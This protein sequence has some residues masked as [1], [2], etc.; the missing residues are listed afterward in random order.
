MSA[1][2]SPE[3]DPRDDAKRRAAAAFGR[4]LDA[5]DYTLEAAARVLR[6]SIT[7]V[8]KLRSTDPAHRDAVPS[9]VDVLLADHV[10]GE[11]FLR[12][13]VV[14]RLALHGEAPV[15]T[16]EQRVTAATQ[17]ALT[18][19]H[20]GVGVMA[21]GVLEGPEKPPLDADAAALVDEVQALRA[22]LR[23]GGPK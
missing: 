14:E 5:C 20:R 3:Q 23:E 9:V 16:I 22:H 21:D 1:T 2:V 4:A 12:E 13:L 17:R 19:A 10:L 18:F 15:V 6:L 11:H 7:R 8:H